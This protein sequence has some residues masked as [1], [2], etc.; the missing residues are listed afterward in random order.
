[1]FPSCLSILSAVFIVKILSILWST[2]LFFLF[3]LLILLFCR[4]NRLQEVPDQLLLWHVYGFL[5][6]ST[7]TK[8][9]FN[10]R[11]RI[12]FSSLSIT[13]SESSIYYL[14][15][16]LKLQVFI[17]SV[18]FLRFLIVLTDCSCLYS[19]FLFS[20]FVPDICN[21]HDLPIACFTD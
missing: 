18:I 8:I 6:I 10:V 12:A 19:S 2:F 11:N 7:D 21:T 9:V 13:L 5:C 16:H 3:F 17:Y 15:Q 20:V 4:M 14:M 1:M